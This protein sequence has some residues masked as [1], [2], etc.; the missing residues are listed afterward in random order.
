[1]IAQNPFAVLEIAAKIQLSK[2]TFS[3]TNF[4]Q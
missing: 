3:L 1:M 4:M 2:M